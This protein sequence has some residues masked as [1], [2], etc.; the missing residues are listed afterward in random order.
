MADRNRPAAAP[1]QRGSRYCFT[2]HARE[3]LAKRYGIDLTPALADLV[4]QQVM[5]AAMP[6]EGVPV[7]RLLRPDGPTRAWWQV[8]LAGQSVVVVVELMPLP[9]IITAQPRNEVRP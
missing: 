1:P 3:R 8:T 2:P 9:I 6:T 7:G 4:F 5:A